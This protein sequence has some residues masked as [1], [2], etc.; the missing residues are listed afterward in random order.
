VGEAAP[1]DGRQRP[2][3][4]RNPGAQV[5]QVPVEEYCEQPAMLSKHWPPKRVYCEAQL[6]HVPVALLLRHPT[7]FLSWHLPLTSESPLAQ[8]EQDPVTLS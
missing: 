3:E 8:A 2:P 5:W 1:R 6:M 7:I 4:S